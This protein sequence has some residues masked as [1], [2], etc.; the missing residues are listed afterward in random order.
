MAVNISLWKKKKFNYGRAG[1]RL[2]EAYS[3][4]GTVL[5]IAMKTQL[6]K[7]IIITNKLKNLEKD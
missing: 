6:V 3:V 7:M 2:M 1:W 5:V 4:C